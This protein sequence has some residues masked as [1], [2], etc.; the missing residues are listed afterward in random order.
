MEFENED[1]RKDPEVILEKMK[2]YC[3]EECNETYERYIFNRRDQET[4]ESVDAYVTALRKLVKTCNYGSLTDSLIR[5]RMV[6][7][8]NDNSARKKLLQTS[9]LTLGQC[10]DICR[11]SQTPSRQ[12]KEMNQEDVRLVRDNKKKTVDKRNAKVPEKS[13]NEPHER[14]CKFCSRYHPFTKKNC[15]AWGTSCNN[16]GKLNHF[17]V[18]CQESRKK[19]L[20]V[21]Y[22]SEDEE[23]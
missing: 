13:Q 7:G 6:V 1:Q 20:S 3:I 9:K 23:Y 8:I 15:P 12:L 19:V 14:K 2:D 18:C 4:N 11:S 10:I 21:D 16:C 5:D 22:T 17:A